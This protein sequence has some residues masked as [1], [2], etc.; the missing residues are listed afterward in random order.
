MSLRLSGHLLLGVVKIYSRKI[1]YLSNDCT[2]ALV[3]IRMVRINFLKLIVVFYSISALLMS[4]SLR[5]C[6]CLASIPFSQLFRFPSPG[7]PSRS[8]C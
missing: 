8:R 2:E 1:F 4:L 3:K 6:L 5:T 7:L